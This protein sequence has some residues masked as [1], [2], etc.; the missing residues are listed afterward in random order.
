MS[1][2][3]VA[4]DKRGETAVLVL[5]PADRFEVENATLLR[6][7]ARHGPAHSRTTC[8]KSADDN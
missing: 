4:C 5:T 7:P 6:R 3:T 1:V 8:G 2:P